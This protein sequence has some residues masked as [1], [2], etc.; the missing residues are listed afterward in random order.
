MCSLA[1]KVL[2]WQLLGKTFRAL[3]NHRQS[4]AN[5]SKGTSVWILGSLRGGGGTHPRTLAE[6][7]SGAHS[8]GSVLTHPWQFTPH[9]TSMQN[10]HT[11]LNLGLLYYGLYSFI[12]I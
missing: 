6:R 12:I 10:T 11:P 5:A 7:H 1:T 8:F 4:A 2:T 3:E 9:P